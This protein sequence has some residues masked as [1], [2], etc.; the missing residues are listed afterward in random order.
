MECASCGYPEL[1]LTCIPNRYLYSGA[2]VASCPT[3][4]VITYSNPNGVC[5]SAFQCTQG[6]YALNISK[7]C[8][9]TCPAG[10]YVNIPG[11]TC[12]PCMRGCLVCTTSSTCATCNTTVSVWS[13]YKCY[14]FCSPRN[15]FYGPTGCVPNC[16]KGMYL[17]ITTCQNC[18]SSCK[19]CIVTA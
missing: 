19:T 1:C 5:G 9:R 18:S 11:Q 10:H 13:D 8:V 17:N 16:P 14:V 7:S 4:P 12:D 15:R 2:C 6:Y 3:F